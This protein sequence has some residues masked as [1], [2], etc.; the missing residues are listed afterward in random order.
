MSFTGTWNLIKQI[1][2]Y[3]CAEPDPVIYFVTFA[4]AVAPALIDFV[5]YGCRDIVKFKAGV[6]QPCGRIFKALAKQSYGPAAVDSIHNILKFTRP[7]EAGLF[8]WFVADLAS[9]TLARWVTLAY[10]LNGCNIEGETASFQ[11]SWIPQGATGAGSPHPVIGNVVN[12][13][14]APGLWTHSGC[15]VPPGWYWQGSFDCQVHP[16]FSNQNTGL[17]TWLQVSSPGSYDYPANTYG[18]GYDGG[19]RT[20]HYTAGGQNT[21]HTAL[22]TVSMWCQTEQQSFIDDVKGYWTVSKLP[23]TN[24]ALSILSCFRD[25]TV[26]STPDPAGR[27]RQGRQPTIFDG[28]LPKIPRPNLNRGPPGGK[29]RSKG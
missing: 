7:I 21:S 3:P 2:A 5:S 27:N 28:W 4:P 14:G 8:W 9:D 19:S 15:I 18:P 20:G 26:S 12:Y 24:S 25:L 13:Q 6:G 17:K 10:Q 23:I 16:V 29:P 1:Q 22:R 11:H